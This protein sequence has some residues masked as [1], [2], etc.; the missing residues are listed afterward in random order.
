MKKYLIALVFVAVVLQCNSLAFSQQ[1]AIL[2]YD[3]CLSG[4]SDK[5]Q[6]QF[7]KAYKLYAKGN[8]KEAS[9]LLRELTVKDENFDSPF[10]LLGLIGLRTGNEQTKKKMFP[11]CL[12]TCPDYSAPLLYY[13]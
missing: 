5:S 4:V 8:L 9:I 7:S 11:K 1:E 13:Y 6:K 12:E 2:Q 3:N 10:Y